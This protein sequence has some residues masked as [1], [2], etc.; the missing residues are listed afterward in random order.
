MIKRVSHRAKVKVRSKRCQYR[1][2]AV[3]DSE[4]EEESRLTK[5]E[6]AT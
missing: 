6:R 2:A 3:N 5:G 4:M 1:V